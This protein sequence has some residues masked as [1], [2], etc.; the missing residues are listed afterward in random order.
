MS[1]IYTDEKWEQNFILLQE[2]HK[3]H[4]MFPKQKDVYKGVKLGLWCANQRRDVVNGKCL[5]ERY[6]KLYGIGFLQSNTSDGHWELNFKKLMLFMDEHG[7]LPKDGEIYKGFR[8]GKWCANQKLQSK[9]PDYP[10]DRMLKLT[11][12]GFF[13]NTHTA[14]WEQHYSELE[15]FVT[16]YGRFPKRNEL[17]EEFNLGAWCTEQKRKVAINTYPVERVRKLKEIGLIK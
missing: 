17:F 2:F 7:R 11:K 6:A 13:D 10:K 1:K 9:L 3:K 12:I 16:E 14:R 5:P 15:R 8:I 4:G